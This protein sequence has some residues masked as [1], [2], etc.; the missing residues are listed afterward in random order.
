MCCLAGHLGDPQRPTDVVAAAML[1]SLR[2]R[3]PDDQGAF[4]FRTR[5]GA[6]GLLVATRLSILDVSPDGHQPMSC[7]RGR[8]H[9]AYNGEIYTHRALRDELRAQ[10][11]PFRSHSDTEVILVGYQ[12]WGDALWPRLQGMFALA[13]WDSERD[14]L[15]LVRDR[16]GI[17]PLYYHLAPPGPDGCLLFA[18]ELRPLARIAA[19][20]GRP[21]LNPAALAGFLTWGSVPEPHCVVRGVVPVPPGHLLRARLSP[22][23]SQLQVDAPVPFLAPSASPAADAFVPR[24]QAVAQLRTALLRTVSGHLESDVPV[25]ILLSGGIDSTAIATLARAAAPTQALH[26]FTLALPTTGDDGDDGDDGDESLFAAQTAR[27]L[28][29][30]HHIVRVT[31]A[32]LPVQSA[33]WLA[34]LDQPTLDGFNTFLIC[35]HVQAHARAQAT[36]CKVVLSGAGGDELFFGYGLHRRFAHVWAAFQG[37]CALLPPLAQPAIPSL[38]ATFASHLYARLRRLFPTSL[39]STLAAL[40][41]DSASSLASWQSA[42]LPQP[43]DL[44]A[45]PNGTAAGTPFQ[46]GLRI[47]QALERRNYLLSTLL[48]DGDVLSMASSIELRVPLCDPTLW[49]TTAAL[50][51]LCFETGKAP[52]VAAAALDDRSPVW[53]AARRPKR[54]F[55][56]PL[57][58]WLRG[59]LSAD[60]GAHLTD[61]TLLHAAG[62][63][64]RPVAALWQTFRLMSSAPQALRRRLAHRI[65]ALYVW[66]A[67]VDR[68][69]L[70]L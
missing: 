8:L 18:S 31:S 50:P 28:Q 45:D 48:H 60:V 29:L 6:P 22:P 57:D 11:G 2:H 17:K 53:A 62:L 24:P 33:D 20:T 10:G 7:A 37:A 19:L 25:G 46:H 26:A 14:E 42:C 69:A 68:H 1:S 47:V 70:A 52:L 39:L 58:V 51:P 34:A 21:L 40:P 5:A 35:R 3:G 27:A 32:D 63:H 66:L 4:P 13:L 36:G 30:Q 55:D 16:M 56:L 15:R 65:W 54:G 43:A 38:S 44:D 41:T 59:P 49:Q 12:M 61:R 9:I 67:Y 64:P 23:R